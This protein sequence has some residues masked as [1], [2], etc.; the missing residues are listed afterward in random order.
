MPDLMMKVGILIYKVHIFYS[1][2][3][4]LM[5][6]IEKYNEMEVNTWK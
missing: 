1:L 2:L 4:Y 5:K 6:E 3:A